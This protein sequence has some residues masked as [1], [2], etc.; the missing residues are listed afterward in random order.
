MRGAT[1]RALRTV[2]ANSRPSVVASAPLGP[3]GAAAEDACVAICLLYNEGRQP[4]LSP[5][6]LMPENFHTS[7]EVE[8]RSRYLACI[9]VST[10]CL[11]IKGIDL[12]CLT[13]AKDRV[14]ILDVAPIIIEITSGNEHEAADML[15]DI[16]HKLSLALAA[17][18]Y[19]S[20]AGIS[21]WGCQGGKSLEKIKKTLE[22]LL[23]P[24]RQWG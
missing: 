23:L 2:C 12:Q 15:L 4:I 20:F 16:Q 10:H 21:E 14:R 6:N 19:V 5:A 9:A 18:V 11:G 7:S 8:M 24:Q 22:K 1:N 3:A 13:P 17:D